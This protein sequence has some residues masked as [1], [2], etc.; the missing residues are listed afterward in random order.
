MRNHERMNLHYKPLSFLLDEFEW[1]TAFEENPQIHF[2]D[3][4]DFGSCLERGKGL[5]I[6]FYHDHPEDNFMVLAPENSFSFNLDGVDM[7]IIGA[8]DLIEQDDGG[9]IIITDFKNRLLSL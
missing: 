5:L 1:K 9:N 2:Y 4:E 7:P 3:G 8:M 6:A